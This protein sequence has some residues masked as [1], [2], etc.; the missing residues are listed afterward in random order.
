M[1]T[2]I[3]RLCK[4]SRRE[5]IRDVLARDLN[6]YDGVGLSPARLNE[7]AGNIERVL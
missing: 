5:R 4:R 7:I 2:L 1:R 3:D 6:V